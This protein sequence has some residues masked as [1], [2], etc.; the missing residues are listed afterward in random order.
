MS[1][2]SDVQASATALL[3]QLQGG[4][5]SAAD[6]FLPLIYTELHRIA[7]R[8]LA[9]GRG[10][11]FQTTDLM[12]EAWLKLVESAGGRWRSRDHFLAVA[13]RAMRSVL[14]DRSRSRGAL[15]RGENRRAEIDLD[16][17]VSMLEEHSTD[18]VR[19]DEALETLQGAD[20]QLARI[21]EM[22][23]F[24]GMSHE[25]IARALGVSLST[26]ERGWRS[27]RAWLHAQLMGTTVASRARGPEGGNH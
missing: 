20:P 25:S 17:V 14:V 4:D 1:P 9:H 16:E 12:N 22:R 6:E 10:H 26:V 7:Q 8:A 18:L 13:A 21:V 19:V 23:F 11:T 24:G 2:E 15:K 27:A 3:V 5:D